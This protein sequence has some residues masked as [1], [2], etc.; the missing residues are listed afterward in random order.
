MGNSALLQPRGAQT[1]ECP[2]YSDW[3]LQM[4]LQRR[5]CQR[6][7]VVNFLTALFAPSSVP[8]AS[9]EPTV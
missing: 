9:I 2:S 4:S 8:L 5:V 6:G 7:V 1:N 3:G